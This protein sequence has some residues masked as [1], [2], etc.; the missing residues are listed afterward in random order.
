M[1]ET[2]LFRLFFPKLGSVKNVRF[3]LILSN[4]LLRMCTFCL[5]QC[6]ALILIWSSPLVNLNLESWNENKTAAFNCVLQKFTETYKDGLTLVCKRGSE[7]SFVFC[8]LSLSLPLSLS[9]LRFF[10]LS[11]SL[12]VCLFLSPPG[13]WTIYVRRNRKALI[14]IRGW[15]VYTAWTEAKIQSG[16]KHLSK[17]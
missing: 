4:N 1:Q 9:P 12:S 11:A 17:C 2:F 14:L 7:N 6:A 3:S 15:I 5:N 13:Q 10:S 16:T 8:Y